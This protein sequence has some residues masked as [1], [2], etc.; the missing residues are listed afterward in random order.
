MI[1]TVTFN[2]SLDYT[3]QIPHFQMGMVNRSNQEFL[4]CGG[5]GINVSVLLQNLGI[6]SHI[7]GFIAGFTGKQIECE[8]KE[9]GCNTDFVVL[10]KGVSR[11]NIKIK[12]KEETEINGAGPEINELELNRLYEKLKKL[13]QDDI[14]VLSGSVPKCLPNNIYEL[15]AVLLKNTGVKIVVDASGELLDT[16][17]KYK[18]FLIKPNHH[19]LGELFHTT[20]EEVQQ[21]VFYGKKLQ[22]R[23]AENVIV[24]MAQKGAV[25][26]SEKQEIYYGIS[27]KGT[28]VNS[29]GAGDSMVAGFLAG[30]LLHHEY[31]EAFRMGLAA[32]SATAFS[33]YLGSSSYIYELLKDVEMQEMPF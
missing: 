10:E 7:F 2:P 21:A 29:T 32:G 17:L 19:E 3:M 24:S 20:I 27:P 6:E 13:K 9:K 28:A 30:Y 4:V 23:G 33:D 31:K 22:S 25:F 15:I 11:I 1:Y 26:I 14:L 12:G 8:L 18:P 5:K 16:T